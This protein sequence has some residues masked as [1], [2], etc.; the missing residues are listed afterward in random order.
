MRHALGDITSSTWQHLLAS[1]WS[2]RAAIV[3]FDTKSSSRM[4]Y[5][6]VEVFWTSRMTLILL[7]FETLA[8][9]LDTE[10]KQCHAPPE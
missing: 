10:R 9:N 4:H 8:G 2:A 1:D 7:W 5:C 3:Q 6:P